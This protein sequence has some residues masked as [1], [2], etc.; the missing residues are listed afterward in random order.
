MVRGQQLALLLSLSLATAWVGCSAG[1]TVPP[2]ADTGQG[3]DGQGGDGQGGDGQGGD[4]QGGD[5]QGGGQSGAAGGTQIGNGGS[6]NPTNSPAHLKGRVVAPEGTIPISGALVYTSSS[7]PPAIPDGVYCDRCVT[8]DASITYTQ[9]NPDGTFNLGSSPGDKYLVVQKGAFRR[10]R[11]ITIVEG[12]QDVPP[13]LT[14]MPPKMDKANGDDVPKIAVVVGAWDP[15]ELVLARMGLEAKVTPSGP[16]GKYQ[17]LSKNATGF[18]VYGIQN[19]GETS[20]YPPSI[21]LL[22]TPSEIE[23]YHIVFIPCSGGS[24]IGGEGNGPA[25][26]G[27]FTG[28]KTA[29]TLEG[30]VRKGGRIYASDWSYEYVRQAFQGFVSWD[31]ETS[32]VG[33]ACQPGGGMESGSAK[34]PGLAAWLGAQNKTLTTVD[35]AW[36]HI[37]SV[38]PVMDVDA[39]NKPVTSTPTVWVEANQNPAATS[40]KHGCGRVLYST[41]HTQPT[42]EITAPLEPQALSLL[43]MILEVGVCINPVDPR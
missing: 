33:S 1:T 26:S 2:G 17:V 14:R 28:G 22:T 21:T 23:K 4:G 20:P 3:G 13:E 18:A 29:S 5:G 6:N 19:L 37:H 42:S 38:N 43:Y 35:D 27:A 12:D 24:N 36:T 16:F 31:G 11:P 34:E 39:D 15:I 30:F 8:L 7:P 40:F 32:T 10:V 9:T 41:Y 25:C